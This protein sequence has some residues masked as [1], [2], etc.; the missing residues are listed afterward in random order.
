MSEAVESAVVEACE[1]HGCDSTRLMDIVR[2]V[3]ER[4]GRVPPAAMERIAELTT[5]PVVEIESLVSFYSFFSREPRGRFVIRLCDDVI[6]RLAGYDRV[7]E[8][9][10]DELG[11]GLSFGLPRVALAG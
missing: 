11:I 9:I 2:G 8:A 6:D 1:R 4:L 5:A 3:Q 7:L 10:E